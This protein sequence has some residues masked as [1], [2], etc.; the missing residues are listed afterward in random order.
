MSAKKKEVTLATT[1][2]EF[3]NKGSSDD[4]P[5]EDTTRPP[6]INTEPMQAL[7]IVRN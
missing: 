7:D 3:D 1:D 6:S 4:N 2:A 5:M